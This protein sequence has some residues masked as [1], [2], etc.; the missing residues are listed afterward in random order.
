MSW[1]SEM[2]FVQMMEVVAKSILMWVGLVLAG[3]YLLGL[4][5]RT[6]SYR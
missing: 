5:L 3:L 6:A 1:T 2:T 4:L